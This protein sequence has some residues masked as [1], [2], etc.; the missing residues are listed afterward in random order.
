MC[1]CFSLQD[2][3]LI[4]FAPWDGSCL[5]FPD[6]RDNG[7]MACS[8]LVVWRVLLVA[9]SSTLLSPRLKQFAA[10]LCHHIDFSNLFFIKFCAIS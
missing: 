9:L 3:S 1:V 6:E 2:L 4:H 7:K 10:D 5:L 8:V